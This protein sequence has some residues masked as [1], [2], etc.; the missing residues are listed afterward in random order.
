MDGTDGTAVIGLF[1]LDALLVP[2]LVF[3]L[4]IFEPR[5]RQMLRD[6]LAAPEDAREFGVVAVRPTDDSNGRP[7]F[8]V[9]TT[10]RVTEVD[11]YPDGRSDIT[12]VGQRRF[13]VV[14]VEQEQPYIRARVTWIPE[15]DAV[16]E[17]QGEVRA[18]ALRAAAVF[19]SYRRVLSSQDTD[20]SDLPDDP[21]MLSYVL[22]AAIVAPAQTRQPL[23][24]SSS[25]L[26]R[27]RLA[28]D[29][30][31]REMAAMQVLPSLPLG[32]QRPGLADRN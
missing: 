20:V 3:P 32:A 29:L 24:Q 26:Q 16:V 18:A 8:S 28:C 1:P 7:W 31:T 14:D 10:A 13:T 30:M 12:T 6:V 2:G 9:G 21:A 25:T 17:E 15:E 11:G 5:Y 22:T 27:L 19:A 23:L 4:H